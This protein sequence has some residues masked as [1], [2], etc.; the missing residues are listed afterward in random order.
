MISMLINWLKRPKA[1]LN[2]VKNWIAP[3]GYEDEAGFHYH[4]F[5]KRTGP[6]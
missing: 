6:R 3:L 4:E 1:M 5:L 2:I